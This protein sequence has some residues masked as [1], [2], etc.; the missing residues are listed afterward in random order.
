MTLK[1]III[2]LAIFFLIRIIFRFFLPVFR[3]VRSAQKTMNDMREQQNQ[4]YQQTKQN[5]TT[6]TFNNTSQKSSKNVEGEY[7]DFEEVK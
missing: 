1:T 2:G 5:S 7:I 6:D 4:Y 3:I